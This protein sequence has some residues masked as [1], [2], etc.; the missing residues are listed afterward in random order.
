MTASWDMAC[1]W[2][3]WEAVRQKGASRA[4]EAEGAVETHSALQACRIVF[5]KKAFWFPVK[6]AN[7]QYRLAEACSLKKV[8][9]SPVKSANVYYRLAES[10]FSGR[11]LRFSVKSVNL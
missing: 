7:L 6:S 8:F 5:S 10:C 11:V 1:A 3:S 2:I 4:A 9:R